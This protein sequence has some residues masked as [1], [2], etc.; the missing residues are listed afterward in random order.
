MILCLDIFQDIEQG[1]GLGGCFGTYSSSEH[2]GMNWLSRWLS[3]V[4]NIWT[5]LRARF[6]QGVMPDC[7]FFLWSDT[8]FM[9][10]SYAQTLFRLRD[11]LVQAGVPALQARQYTLHSLKTTYLSW[12][13]LLSIPVSISSVLYSRD[14]VWPA[15]RT[16]ASH[17]AG[18]P[19]RISPT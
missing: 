16:P 8:S 5:S 11:F 2:W 15:L 19:L 10:A 12:M 18:Y 14:E 6:G 3:I 17:V 9:P 7:L 4:D 1:L 13:G